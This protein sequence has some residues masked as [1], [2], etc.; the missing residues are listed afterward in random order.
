MKRMLGILLAAGVLATST[1]PA[2]TLA[3]EKKPSHSAHRAVRGE[4]HPKMRAAI[5][6]LQAARAELE[7]ADTDFGGYR[8]DALES[9]DNA[10][11]RLRL[12]LQFDKQ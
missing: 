2:A 6:A 1:H 5:A 10:L 8:K 3:Q 7:H 11:K 9:L 4:R 12:A